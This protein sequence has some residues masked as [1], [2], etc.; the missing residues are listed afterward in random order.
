MSASPIYTIK[1]GAS[2]HPESSVLQFV[3]DL[4]KT[5]GIMDIVNGTQF[6]VNQKASPGMGVKVHLGRAYLLASG[7]NGYPVHMDTDDSSAVTVEANVSG[8]PRIDA[9]VL[10]V[11]TGGT[12]NSDGSG[13][14]LLK[15]VAGTP[16][17]SPS[18]PSDSTIQS[19]VGAGNPFIRLA[20]LAVASGASSILDS[21]ITDTRTQV[22]F[23]S[24]L[25]NQ[26]AWVPVAAVVGGTTNIDLSLGKKFQVTM[27]AGNTTFALKNVPLIPKSFIL[28]I[29]Q[30]GVGGRTVTFWGS[31]DWGVEGAPTLSTDPSATDEIAFNMLT[32]VSD[33]VNSSEGIIVKQGL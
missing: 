21:N 22:A 13:V 7:G 32:V 10:Y 27:G 14:A 5:T 25:L 2:A 9:V 30:D 1:S 6:K 33:S 8:N 12:P 17:A 29:T 11:N 28:R 16:G 24:D 26:D 20:N 3:T 4:L 31:L 23:R 15:D 18:A 19:S